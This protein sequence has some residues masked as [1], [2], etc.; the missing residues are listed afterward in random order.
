MSIFRCLL[1]VGAGAGLALGAA[2]QGLAFAAQGNTQAIA[3]PLVK[4]RVS[5]STV[6]LSPI[7]VYGQH[8]PVPLILQ[9]VK[10]GLHRTWS[11]KWADRGKLVCR[12]EYML[13][14]HFQTLKCMTNGEHFKVQDATQLAMINA[15]TNHGEI[16]E[17]IADWTNGHIINPGAMKAL[18][19]RL[20]PLGSSYT[21]RVTAAH[22]KPAID[23]VI[24]DGEL[25]AIHRYIAK[26]KKKRD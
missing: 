6:E 4:Y 12:F 23:Y 22:G 1:M 24:E 2:P 16:P 5:R 7:V 20:P 15:Y 9:M 11:G 14:T 25:T 18:L 13:G 8:L 21:L 3:A 10:T 26:G 19:K 17:T